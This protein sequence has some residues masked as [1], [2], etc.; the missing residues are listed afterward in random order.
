MSPTCQ[1]K[2]FYV[3]T[4]VHE[5]PL[6]ATRHDHG[7]LGGVSLETITA[8]RFPGQA[9]KKGP[10][11]IE[12]RETAATSRSSSQDTQENENQT[13]HQQPPPHQQQQQQQQ[14][15]SLGARVLASGPAEPAFHN[16]NP[17][18]RVSLR[19]AQE[20]DFHKKLE[21]IEACERRGR[22]RSSSEPQ[23]YSLRGGT[24]HHTPLEW[25]R[26]QQHRQRADMGT[27]NE[28][29]SATG[30]KAMPSRTSLFSSPSQRPPRRRSIRD[31]GGGDPCADACAQ[32]TNGIQRAWSSIFGGGEQEEEQ[33]GIGT[34]RPKPVKKKP[35]ARV[36]SV[37][38][39]FASCTSTK[40]FE[41]SPAYTEAL[42]RLGVDPETTTFTMHIAGYR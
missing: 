16:N 13:W 31:Y 26:P 10:S 24:H 20:W 18:R 22:Q 33:H 5:D 30:L 23:L 37:S 21:D 35:A 1:K 8:A 39:N 19:E 41:S 15:G 12:S 14:Q 28:W 27:V 36:S 7:H 4:D 38:R 17:T 3:E 2:L 40:T 11:S 6:V 9:T 25:H 29:C 32:L 42:R 34:L